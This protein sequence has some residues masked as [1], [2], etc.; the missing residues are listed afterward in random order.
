MYNT[1]LPVLVASALVAAEARLE[2][3]AQLTYR[4]AIV[5]EKGDPR[6]TRK[7]VQVTY[8]ASGTADAGD[9]L[10]WTL[11]EKGRGGWRW[12]DRFGT[13]TLDRQGRPSGGDAPALLYLHESGRNVLPLAPPAFHAPRAIETGATWK[14]ESLEWRVIGPARTAGRDT[15]RIEAR[16]K[17]GH[18]RTLWVERTSPL[19]VA[20][21]ETV[22][23][24]PGHEHELRLDLASS[25]TLP[26]E[27]LAAAEESFQTL[28]ALRGAVG[29][30]PRGPDADWGPEQLAALKAKLPAVAERIGAGPLAD[31][32]GAALEDLDTQ[33]GRSGALAAIRSRYVGRP[34]EAFRLEGL[35]LGANPVT[36]DTIKNTVTVFHFWEYRD[37]PLESPYGQVGYLDYLFR[38]RK[39]EGVAVYGVAVDERFGGADTHRAATAG[40]KKLK[41]FM[42][43]SYPLLWDD[44]R[45]LKVFGDPRITGAKLPLFV[46]VK[47]DGSIAHYHVG[48][49]ETR[50]DQGLAELDAAISGAAKREP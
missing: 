9:T 38:R 12:P 4:G 37:T 27:K 5:A 31:V 46:V 11:E 42:N 33:R 20:M 36:L 41:E 24:G 16:A 18:K 15:W 35:D 49:Y 8:L 14:D 34:V 7:E 40:A 32:A 22:F 3:G 47:A 44:G 10:H 25:E 28:A 1:L 17:Y 21:S 13:L 29:W 6:D 26:A 50:S 39:A 48:L 2:K 19:V 23:M 30:K 45:V 43:L